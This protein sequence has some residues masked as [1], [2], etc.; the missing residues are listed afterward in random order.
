MKTI[1]QLRDA[2]IAAYLQPHIE[3]HTAR[4]VAAWDRW[5]R[6][7]PGRIVQA[8]SIHGPMTATELAD[9]TGAV[10]QST[11]VALMRMVEDGRAIH[12]DQRPRRYDIVW[13]EVP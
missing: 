9:Y 13:T 8:I 4:A 6:S 12:D 1:P 2:Y 11:R 3:T 10:E 5:R 7:L